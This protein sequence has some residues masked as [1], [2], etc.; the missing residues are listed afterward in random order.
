MSAA[1]TERG[2]LPPPR[3]GRVA[4]MVLAGGRGTR[5]G[6]LD[7]GLQPYRGVPLA[8][9]ALQRLRA[10]SGELIGPL[11]I[12]ANRH[13]AAYAAFGAPVVADALPDFAG[14]LAG[15][16]A[17]LALPDADWLLTVPCDSPRF[18]L[19]LA[20][21]LAEAVERE[22]AQIA[23]AAGPD[24]EQP[25]PNPPLRAQPVFCLIAMPMR[26]RLE[27]FLAEGG[28]RIDRWTG[29][30]RTV[31]V[32]FDRPDDDPLAFSNANTLAELQGLE[33]VP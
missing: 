6:G 18:P 10:Q 21:R 12:N 15:F 8:R 32:P 1:S 31:I 27:T 9:H 7:K 19:D 28:R 16:L 29:Q 26:A 5:M 2:A 3:P 33:N 25:G 14:P 17:G 4:A 13:A 20:A 23:I 30:Q 22:G 24:T 11:A